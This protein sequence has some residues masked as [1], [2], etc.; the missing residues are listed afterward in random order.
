GYEYGSFHFLEPSFLHNYTD[1]TIVLFCI[2]KLSLGH[3]LIII[4]LLSFSVSTY[5]LRL[6]YHGIVH[7]TEGS[8]KGA[9]A[10]SLLYFVVT[11]IFTIGGILNG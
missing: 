7:Y 3:Y 2:M 5:F 10:V 1:S 6:L 9:L 4:Q 11:G 8:E